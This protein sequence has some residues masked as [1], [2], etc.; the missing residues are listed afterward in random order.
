MEGKVPV[1][2]AVII[3]QISEKQNKIWRCIMQGGQG[4]RKRWP[5]LGKIP[6]MIRSNPANLPQSVRFDYPHT[7]MALAE[8]ERAFDWPSCIPSVSRYG[9]HETDV[10]GYFAY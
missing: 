5:S 7:V 4:L 9:P 1:S 3:D 2:I 8:F 6:V 10:K